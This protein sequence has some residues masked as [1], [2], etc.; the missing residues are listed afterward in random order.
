ML[1]CDLHMPGMSGMALHAELQSFAPDLARR[2]VFLTG[3]ADTPRARE[4][5]E[6]VS[7]PRLDKP[8]GLD[9][10]REAIDRMLAS[11]A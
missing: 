6:T 7:N 4:F 5:F 1:L 11:L 10:L 8:T 9:A 3:G 2:M